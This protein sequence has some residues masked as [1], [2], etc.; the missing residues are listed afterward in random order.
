VGLDGTG[1]SPEFLP[2]AR[3]LTALL[4]R[5]GATPKDQDEAIKGATNVA[6]VLVTAKLPAAGAREGDQIECQVASCGNATSLQGGRLLLTALVGPRPDSDRVY[7]MAEGNIAVEGHRH[8]LTG[9]IAGGC[10]V[11]ED[12]ET[13]RRVILNKKSGTI[14]ISGDAAISP[15]VISHGD[16]SIDSTTAK[17][18]TLIESLNAAEV[19]ADEI[20]TIIERIAKA[21]KLYAKL[22]VK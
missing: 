11:E 16:F 18:R 2:T 9:R 20:M 1:D 14:V 12:I 15:V 5:M 10:R 22:I 17:L 6:L 21:G 7:A 3:S 19:S 4:K 8:L 13:P